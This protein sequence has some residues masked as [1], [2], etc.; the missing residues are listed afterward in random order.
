MGADPCHATAAA[1]ARQNLKAAAATDT[2]HVVCRVV[3]G[4][5]RRG[6][7]S[8]LGL[9]RRLF[10]YQRRNVQ[11]VISVKFLFVTS[12]PSQLEKL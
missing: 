10:P 1:A 8:Q 6:G 5:V 7:I 12:T 9:I 3:G 11:T 2:R 4:L